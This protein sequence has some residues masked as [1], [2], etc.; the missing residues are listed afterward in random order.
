MKSTDT[1]ATLKIAGLA[2]ILTLLTPMVTIMA[3]ET[4]DGVKTWLESA[5]VAAKDTDDSKIPLDAEQE[6]GYEKPIPL[7][8]SIEYTLVSDYIFRGINF[9]EYAGEG[10]EKP[11]HQMAAG[12]EYDTGD[13]GAVGFSAWFEWYADQEVFTPNE[14]THLQ[15][16]DYTVYWSYEIPDTPVTVELGWIAYTFPPLAGDAH[17]TNEVYAK[18]SVDDGFIF[19]TDEPVLNPYVYYG[20]DVDDGQQG[21]WLEF[22]VSHDFVLADCKAMKSAPILKDITV[23]PSAVLAVDNRY[24]D[25]F[26]VLGDGTEQEAMRL[27]YMQYGLNV[28]YD[29]SSGLNIPP[30]YGAM[31]LSGFVNFN[32]AF[33]DD[34]LNDE[35]WGGVSLGYEW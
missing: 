20:L 19:G 12:V 22:G 3:E 29:L 16:V 34:L 2:L 28:S 1:Q 33:R 5:P 27:A 30:Q 25:K 32:Q 9:S 11:N 7:T 17:D 10:R 14:N 18:V 31:T 6:H 26:D 21:S 35:M 4:E 23:T 8:F 15:E 24:L 13:F